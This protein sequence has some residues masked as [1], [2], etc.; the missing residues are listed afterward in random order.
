[1]WKVLRWSRWT[2]LGEFN[3]NAS[4]HFIR[5]GC[6][7]D[8]NADMLLLERCPSVVWWVELVFAVKLLQN[9]PSNKI[10][11]RVCYFVNTDQPRW[12]LFTFLNLCPKFA[13]S[14]DSVSVLPPT[15]VSHRSS[16]WML[17]LSVGGEIKQ[18]ACHFMYGDVQ[19][20]ALL[21]EQQTKIW[22]VVTLF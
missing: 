7:I 8:Q 3:F 22:Q 2:L 9:Q 21:L 17:L 4:K 19:H 10:R 16:L 5:A 18:A 6:H 20:F 11:E 13:F 15:A 1:M 14:Q 12:R